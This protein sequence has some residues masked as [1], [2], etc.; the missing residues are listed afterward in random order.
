MN[1]IKIDT[2]KEISLVDLAADYQFFKKDINQAVMK[3]FSSGHFL[4]G[5]QLSNLENEVADYLDIQYS[6]G[7]GSGTD[8]LTIAI[9]SLG[10]NSR[11]NIIVPAN[12]YPSVF[13]VALS[14]VKIKLA[15]VDP[16]SLNINLEN[17]KKAVDDKTKAILAVHLYGNP[18]DLEPLMEFSR[19]NNIFLIED[20]AQAFGAVYKGKKVGILS[21]IACFSFYPTKILGAY[22]DGGMVVSN[23]EELIKKAKSLRVYG[24]TK[25]YESQELGLNS[26]LDEVQSAILRVKLKKVDDLNLKRRKLAKIYNDNLRDTPLSLIEEN[27]GSEAVYHL[28]VLKTSKRD[29]LRKFLESQNIQTSVHYPKPIHFIETFQS[30]NYKKGDFPIAENASMQVLSIPIHPYMDEDG[31]I[32]IAS[33]IKEFFS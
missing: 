33:K 5:E 9:K 14:G 4:L 19:S 1:N 3:V 16:G 22:G 8:A 32:F 23:N 15:D 12:V 2:G 18:V 7:V 21:D 13:G 28:Y 20:C 17:V 31:A 26:R 6:A 27:N 10:L 29:K 11:D 30:L 24:E 25:R